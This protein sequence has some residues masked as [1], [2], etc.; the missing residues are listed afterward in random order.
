M[1]TRKRRRA[2]PL[3]KRMARDQP[4]PVRGRPRSAFLSWLLANDLAMVV[5]GGA[6][7]GLILLMTKALPLVSTADSLLKLL[8]GTWLLGMFLMIT[9][10]TESDRKYARTGG[11]IRTLAGAVAAAG[12]VSLCGASVDAM[13][14][15]AIVGGVLGISARYWANWL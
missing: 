8:A 14:L 7:F 6:A 4:P 2:G 5:V 11:T 9:V 13:L 12:I 15:A 10:V 1:T 3:N